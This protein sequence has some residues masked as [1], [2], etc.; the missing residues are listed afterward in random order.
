MIA[1]SAWARARGGAT[2]LGERAAERGDHERVG[3]LVE[4]EG[5]GLAGAAD[6]AAG[7]AGEADEVVALPAGG[8]AGEVWGEAGRQQQLEGER[9]R[10]GLAGAD[11]LAVEQR[12]LV[13]E[14]VVDADVRV[15]VVEDACDRLA[16]ARRAVQRAAVVAQVRVGGEGLRPR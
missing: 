12:E 15:A 8:A 4:A 14:Q 16:G 10:V 1:R 6:D 9:E 3:V 13:G 7:G 5:A 2:G 11:G